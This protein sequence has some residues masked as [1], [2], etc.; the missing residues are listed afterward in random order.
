MEVEIITNSTVSLSYMSIV[1]G[2]IGY[3]IWSPI[4]FLNYISL[5]VIYV[6][7]VLVIGITIVI[8]KKYWVLTFHPFYCALNAELKKFKKKDQ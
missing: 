6:L 4:D 8:G 5:S 7:I 2:L 1:R 3:D